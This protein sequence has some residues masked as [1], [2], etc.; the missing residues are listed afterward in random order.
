MEIELELQK[1]NSTQHLGFSFNRMVNAGFTGRDQEQV[2]H[3]LDELSAKG[4]DV[5]D[6]TPLIY[7]VVPTALCSAPEIEV[8]GKESSAEVEYVLFVNQDNQVFVGIGSDHTDRNLEEHDIPRAKQICPNMFSPVVWDLNEVSGHWDDLSMKCIVQKNQE[9]I[10][11]Q[12]GS[13]ALLMSPDELMAFVSQKVKGTL[14]NS[15]IFS[16]TVKMETESFVYAD[17]VWVELNDPVLNRSIQF[18]YAVKP[19][20]YII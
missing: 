6:E 20:D 1:K 7:P 13:L 2:K 5:P 14:K 12:Q 11:Y 10:L 16:G 18:S 8:Y 15:V 19:L 3:H 9:E 4:I 17:N